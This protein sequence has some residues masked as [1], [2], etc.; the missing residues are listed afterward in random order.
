MG[1]FIAQFT[2][3]VNGLMLPL[4][5]TIHLENDDSLA[6]PHLFGIQEGPASVARRQ[7]RFA[8]LSSRA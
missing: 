8:R 1:N 3:E 6:D 5:L 7:L 4:E 2:Y